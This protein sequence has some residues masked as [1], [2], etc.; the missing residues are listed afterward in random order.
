ERAEPAD[1]QAERADQ[2]P[3]AR[4]QGG[5]RV[6]LRVLARPVDLEPTGRGLDPERTL[7]G[8]DGCRVAEGYLH[9][10]LR[11]VPADDRERDG[12][13]G[14]RREIFQDRLTEH[15]LIALPV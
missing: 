9:V 4:R 13:A 8:C 14:T 11:A 5:G 7:L 3:R 1:D 10:A 6:V 15:E 2:V 12:L